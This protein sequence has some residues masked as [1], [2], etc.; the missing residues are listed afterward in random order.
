MQVLP[1]RWL[2][3]EAVFEDDYSAKSDVY[4]YGVLV[5]EIFTQA[6]FPFH[7]KTDND[8][9]SSLQNHELHW[10][11]PKNCTPA[12]TALLGRCWADSPRDR[13]TFSQIVL[14]ISE[15]KVDTE[16]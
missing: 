16:M 13:P 10:K 12:M 1:L 15:M 5:W 3:H 8:V 14:A 7:R 11:I 2:P 4:S 9:L 6:E